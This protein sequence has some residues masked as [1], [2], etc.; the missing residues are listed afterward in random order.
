MGNSEYHPNPCVFVCPFYHEGKCGDN[1]KFRLNAPSMVSQLY[2]HWQSQH[3]AR[4]PAVRSVSP[5]RT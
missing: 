4:G 5:G 1:G 3:A 2:S